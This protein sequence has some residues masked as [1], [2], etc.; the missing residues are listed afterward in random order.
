[1][2]ADCAACQRS[3]WGAVAS[4]RAGAVSQR[5]RHGP[6]PQFG[7]R[8][9]V[10]MTHSVGGRR[11]R[12]EEAPWRPNVRC[13][14]S[15]ASSGSRSK[16]GSAPRAKV[17]DARLRARETRRERRM[18]TAPR[19]WTWRSR[20]PS[21]PSPR[22]SPANLWSQR[23]RDATGR[24]VFLHFSDAMRCNAGPRSAARSQTY[25]AVRPLVR[26]REARVPPASSSAR[27]SVRG[28]A[29]AARSWT[30]QRTRR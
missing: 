19:G 25:S 11:L 1:M 3:P 15:A 21:S 22:T 7:G 16:S 9:W 27:V 29:M 4:Q 18:R 23:T 8:R 12:P 24:E 6:T 5:P 10:A 2:A 13:P 30:W 28:P 14:S 17:L 26:L 20:A